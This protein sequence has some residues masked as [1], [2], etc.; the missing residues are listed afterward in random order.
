MQRKCDECDQG[1]VNVSGCGQI[2][3]V[4]DLR[5]YERGILPSKTPIVLA[6]KRLEE[7]ARKYVDWELIKNTPF[8]EMARFKNYDKFLVETLKA[9]GLADV[10]QDRCVDWGWSGDGADLTNLRK[11]T[12]LG[13][14]LLDLEAK[15]PGTNNL[16]FHDG[17]N[18]IGNVVLKNYHTK[19]I[20]NFMLI[21][22]TNET[23]ELYLT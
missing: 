14:R 19:E 22:G 2:R 21:C 15:V 20:A 9:Y 10:A 1:G 16:L 8:G 4:Q 13:G 17:I 5:N 7:E 12:S 18:D 11:Q 23:Q 3:E 6:G